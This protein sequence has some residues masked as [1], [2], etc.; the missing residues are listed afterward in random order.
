MEQTDLIFRTSPHTTALREGGRQQLLP[1]LLAPYRHVVVLADEQVLRLYPDEWNRYGTVLPVQASEQQKT[2]ETV[3]RL[4]RQLAGCGADRQTFLLAA[5][6]GITC[7]I[8]GFTASTWMRGIRFGF[9]PTT[10][11]AQVDA[12]VGGKNGVNLDGYKNMAGTFSQ[13]EFV[14]CDTALLATLPEPVYLQGLAEV[15]KTAVISDE[16]FF[17]RLE[18][19][20]AG[21]LAREASVLQYIVRKCV[22]V[23]ARVVTADE[24]ESGLRRI[25]NFG[26]TFAHAIEKHTGMPHGE[27]VSIGMTAA[28]RLAVEEGVCESQALQ[29]FKDLCIRLHLPVA[30]PSE[31]SLAQLCE[32]VEKD[33]KHQDGGV[34]LV[35]PEAIGKVIVR[36][37]TMAQ[38]RQAAERAGIT[39]SES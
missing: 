34:C 21:V 31:V 12:S 28:M 24:K 10:L 1:G 20:A 22:S 5:G 25:L 13:P 39:N 17:A 29:R 8:A 14:L 23:K 30:W 33:K 19:Q 18:Q 32:A 11:L 27:A 15:V 4:Y 2:L 6:G 7:D 9:V 36:P 26:H 16:P 35:L 3:C 37:F 38:F